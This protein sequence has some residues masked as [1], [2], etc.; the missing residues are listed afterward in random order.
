MKHDPSSSTGSIFEQSPL[1]TIEI[2]VSEPGE[3]LTLYYDRAGKR[4]GL[5]RLLPVRLHHWFQL[6]NPPGFG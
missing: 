5:E 3:V 4:R 6:L 2:L 1:K